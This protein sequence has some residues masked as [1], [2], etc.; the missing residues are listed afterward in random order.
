M[1]AAFGCKRAALTT[2]SG[3]PACCCA[4]ADVFAVAPL[5]AVDPVRIRAWNHIVQAEMGTHSAGMLPGVGVPT[6]MSAGTRLATQDE[7]PAKLEG[8]PTR[9]VAGGRS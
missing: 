7:P 9:A 6:G 5:E 1:P 8:F 3:T 2:S 4:C